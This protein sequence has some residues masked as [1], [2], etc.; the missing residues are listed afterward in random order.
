MAK[1]R[2]SS[3]GRRAPR[4]ATQWFDQTIAINALAENQITSTTLLPTILDLAKKGATILRTLIDINIQAVTVN[5]NLIL[6]VGVVMMQSDAIVAGAFPDP[7]DDAEQPGWLYRKSIGLY[8]T[9]AFSTV[10]RVPFLADIKAKR[11]F[12]GEAWELMMIWE[13]DAAV[14]TLNI[15]GLVR[16]LI[17][18]P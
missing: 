4:R 3:R 12:A 1:R 18:K 11:K 16:V 14:G 8:T 17:A 9:D 2:Y 15:Q 10:N 13:R 6:D 5:V 7:A